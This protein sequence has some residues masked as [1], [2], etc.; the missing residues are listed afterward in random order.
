MDYKLPEAE[1]KLAECIWKQG[2][3]TSTELVKWC[4]SAFQWKKST[5]Y[6]LLKRLSDKGVV[7]NQQG[8]VSALISKQMYESGKSRQ[9]VEETF[10]S[11]LPK[12]LAAFSRSRKLS[13]KEIM[14]IKEMIEQYEEE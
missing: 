6:T 4:E 2:E 11:S 12:F 13:S 10:N 14:A 9:F 8:I 5:T 7:Q 1:L 3:I